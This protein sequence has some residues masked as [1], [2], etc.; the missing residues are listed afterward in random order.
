MMTH[1][2]CIRTAQPDISKK[3]VKFISS[4]LAYPTPTSLLCILMIFLI[5]GTPP[6]GH[7]QQNVSPTVAK[8]IAEAEL[9]ATAA[10]NNLTWFAFGCLGGPIPMTAAFFRTAPPAS[11]LLGKSPG[12]I[13]QYTKAYK[14]KARNL[15]LKYATMGFLGGITVGGALFYFR[16]DISDW[17]YWNL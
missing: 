2:Q 7:S 8:A 3:I 9:N 15:R 1:W 11:L 12:Y 14:T 17:L 6:P 16:Y 5:F 4:T 10:T 13:D